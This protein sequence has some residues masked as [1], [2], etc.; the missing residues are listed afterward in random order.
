MRNP[1]SLCV[2]SNCRKMRKYSHLCFCWFIWCFNCL[3]V[4]LFVDQYGICTFWHGTRRI[5]GWAKWVFSDKKCFYISISLTYLQTR[6]FLKIINIP[7]FRHRHHQKAKA[8]WRR[9]CDR[10]E[11]T[12]TLSWCFYRR[13]LGWLF[14]YGWIKTWMGT[15]NIHVNSRWKSW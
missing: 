12:S 13:L 2:N 7:C 1:H 9:N 3:F 14:Q 10:R 15:T 11:R 6:I 5:G 8:C 4:C